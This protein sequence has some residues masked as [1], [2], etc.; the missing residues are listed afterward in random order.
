MSDCKT[1]KNKEVVSVQTNPADFEI[2]D[3]EA[4]RRIFKDYNIHRMMSKE[5]FD[6][7]VQLPITAEQK[8]EMLVDIMKTMKKS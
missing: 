2:R 1:E 3:F 8:A 6:A 7:F 5:D 4:E